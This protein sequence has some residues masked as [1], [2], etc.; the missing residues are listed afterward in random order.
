MPASGFPS[1]HDDINKGVT[2][3]ILGKELLTTDAK[4]VKS[5]AQSQRLEGLAVDLAE[6]DALD[7]IKDIL[8]EPYL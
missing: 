5:S 2:L 4:T 3:G 1:P 6:I 8:I 7:E